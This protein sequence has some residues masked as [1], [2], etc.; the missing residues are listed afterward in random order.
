MRKYLPILA[1]L[2]IES[3]GKPSGPDASS[4]R[5]SE[6]LMRKPA[7]RERDTRGSFAETSADS[8]QVHGK[9]RHGLSF[10]VGAATPS[11]HGKG[12]TPSHAASPELGEPD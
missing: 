9:T 7:H 6:A 10:S 11:S 4:R 5:P 8:S 3:I 12:A 2:E 1:D